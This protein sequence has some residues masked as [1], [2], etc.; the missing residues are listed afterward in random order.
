[1][2]LSLLSEQ[3]ALSNSKCTGDVPSVPLPLCLQALARSLPIGGEIRCEADLDVKANLDVTF[4]MS[5][6]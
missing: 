5:H 2:V 6:C 4:W 3:H 1:M